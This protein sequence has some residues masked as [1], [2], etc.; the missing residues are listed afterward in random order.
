MR[1]C[2]FCV[3]WLIRMCDMAHSYVWHDSYKSDLNVWHTWWIESRS[4]R[5]CVAAARTLFADSPATWQ[6][7]TQSLNPTPHT[8]CNTLQHTATHCNTTHTFTCDMTKNDS[9]I[10]CLSYPMSYLLEWKHMTADESYSFWISHWWMT[11]SFHVCH[12]KRVIHQRNHMI[13]DE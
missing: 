4:A 12:I 3:T 13:A 6:R 11:P 8:H 5:V 1:A 9:F 10:S 2:G 7:M